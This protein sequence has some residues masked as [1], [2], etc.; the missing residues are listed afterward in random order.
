MVPS[1]EERA[2]LGREPISLE[3][4]VGFVWEGVGESAGG[5]EPCH[6]LVQVAPGL[7]LAESAG[8]LGFGPRTFL[9]ELQKAKHPR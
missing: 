8:D 1:C 3:A 4:A 7:G 6:G 9:H 2:A 5:H